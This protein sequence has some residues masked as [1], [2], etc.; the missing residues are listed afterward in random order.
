MIL[1]ILLLLKCSDGEIWL[2][3][4]MLFNTTLE[5]RREETYRGRNI[6]GT[7]RNIC[8]AVSDEQER[9][10]A[11]SRSDSEKPLRSEKLS[12]NWQIQGLFKTKN[13][14]SVGQHWSAL[15]QFC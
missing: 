2:Y 5:H 15:L 7:E 10:T 8:P 14:I 11:D 1:L 4:F 3:R 6:A 13:L 12:C 9:L